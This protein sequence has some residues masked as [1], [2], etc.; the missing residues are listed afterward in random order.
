MNPAK[1]YRP[2]QG[3]MNPGAAPEPGQIQRIVAYPYRLHC[4]RHFLLHVVNARD[5]RKFISGLRVA[6]ASV[7]DDVQAF[8]K[9][10][11]AVN[12][13]FTWVGLDALEVPKPYLRLF[14]EKARAFAEGPSVR[15]ARRLA[16]TGPSSVQWWEP[17]FRHEQA[18]VLLT[19]H[20][21]SAQQ[22]E[23]CTENLRK[24]P[25]AKALDGWEPID[26]AHLDQDRD[27]RT[28][29]FGFRDGVANPTIRNWPPGNPG[30]P[31][32]QDFEAGEFVLGYQNENGFNQWLLVNPGGGANPWQFPLA[33]VDPHFFWNGSFCAFRKM[34][35]HEEAFHD[36]VAQWAKRMNPRAT[37]EY[38][39]AKICGRWDN[40]RVV[41]P[42]ETTA[43]TNPIADLDDFDFISTNPAEDDS[44]GEGC[45]FG[46][47]IR[48]MNPRNDPVVPSRKR[49]LL[50][51][52]MPYGPKY[53][54][55]GDKEERGL[56]GLF[57][58]ANLEDQF[59][60]LLSEWG[61]ANP[62][63]PANRG[64]SKDP[65]T[66]AYGGKSLFDIPVPGEEPRQLQ[67]FR[68]FVT[69]RGTV[70]AFFPGLRGIELISRAPD[71]KMPELKP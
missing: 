40:G 44:K 49:P 22:L 19:L 58:C 1:A 60:H 11:C 13:G 18:H 7:V 43:P 64:T 52:S 2:A 9:D 68:S 26:G 38:V 37:D 12:I 35:Q 65:F 62:M 54:R 56:L 55:S 20:A 48:R 23:R 29:H 53:S 51:R 42:G 3:R 66:G 21:D 36:H 46:S 24:L 71:L 30:K 28:V 67:G 10:G 32:R 41:R 61:D 69:T 14:Q 5:A 50:R 57:F 63:G 59:E 6:D 15:A 34:E 4:S 31:R 39:R 33:H 8:G 16:D 25:G 47:H 27:K 70:Y 45:P 17:R